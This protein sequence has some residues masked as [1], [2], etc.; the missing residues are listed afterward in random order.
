VILTMSKLISLLHR[1]GRDTH[2][3]M[4][5]GCIKMQLVSIKMQVHLCVGMFTLVTSL[6]VLRS[7]Q[8]SV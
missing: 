3:K 5:V 7:K 1:R 8:V 2:T 4:L 6:F